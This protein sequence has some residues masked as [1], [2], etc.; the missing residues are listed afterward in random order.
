MAAALTGRPTAVL[1]CSEDHL[2][3]LLALHPVK[4]ERLTGHRRHGARLKSYILHL[5]ANCLSGTAQIQ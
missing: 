3:V 2:D 5:R 4:G 1:E